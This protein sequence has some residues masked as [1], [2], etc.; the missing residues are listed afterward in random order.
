MKMKNNKKTTPLRSF[1]M[2]RAG[3]G[4]EDYA[5]QNKTISNNNNL[6][7]DLEDENEKN[8]CLCSDPQNQNPEAQQQYCQKLSTFGGSGGVKFG[9]VQIKTLQIYGGEVVD[10]I[11]INGK[12]FGGGGGSRSDTLTLDD[13]EYIN[14][15]NVS[16][17]EYSYKTTIRSLEFKTSNGKSIKKGNYKKNEN[18]ISLTNIKVTEIGGSAGDYLD[19]ITLYF[20]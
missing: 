16:E 14:E 13:G 5:M 1:I 18:V 9:P 15:V 17:I 6:C 3:E 20:F 19:S 10:S 7:K 11:Y 12:I 8:K 2:T 4:R